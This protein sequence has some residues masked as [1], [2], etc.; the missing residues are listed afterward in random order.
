MKNITNDS[1]ILRYNLIIWNSF[2][3]FTNQNN[4]DA[5]DSKAVCLE[6]LNSM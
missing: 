6:H 4:S 2:Y 1:L 5:Y 3:G